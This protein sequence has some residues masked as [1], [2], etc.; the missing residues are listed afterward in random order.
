MPAGSVMRVEASWDNSEENPVNPDASLD[1]PWGDGTNYEM[2]VAFIDFIVDE[3]VKPKRQRVNP[4]IDTLLDRHATPDHAYSVTVDGMGFGGNWGLVLPEEGE[5]TFY[6]MFGSL[7]F[8]ASVPE[9]T[10]LESGE[11]IFN[12]SVI[13]SGGGTRMP[14]GFLAKRTEAGLTGEV[15]MAKEVT[16]DNVDHALKT[17]AGAIGLYTMGYEPSD[18]S[19]HSLRAGGA[20][21]LHLNGCDTATIQKMGRWKS[22]TFL[23]YIH[24]QISAFSAGL[25][26]KM[27]TAIPFVHIAGPRSITTTH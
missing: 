11:L 17:A 14:L 25:S 22:Q 3:G 6:M 4:I 18:I 26:L 15:F 27:S 19:S 7:M 2:L 20:M 16:A 8:S 10:A 1:I 13:T 12:G 24:E 5:P 23:T 9:V 21:A